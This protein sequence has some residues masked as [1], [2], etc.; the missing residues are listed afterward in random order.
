[1]NGYKLKDKDLMRDLHEEIK[2]IK[3]LN[4]QGYAKRKALPLLK[5]AHKELMLVN[6][7]DIH[8]GGYEY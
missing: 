8:G 7:D 6:I 3:E 4:K 1:M 5:R 2:S